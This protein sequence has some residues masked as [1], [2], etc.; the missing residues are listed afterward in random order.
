MSNVTETQLGE[1]MTRFLQRLSQLAEEILPLPVASRLLHLSLL[2]ARVDC[3]VSTQFG[4]AF[5]FTPASV[6]TVHEN[7]RGSRSSTVGACRRSEH[8]RSLELLFGDDPSAPA[9]VS[10]PRGCE[11]Q[12]W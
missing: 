11:Y 7:R 1:Y 12:V 4:V 8:E 3:Y 9:L 10:R 6:T 5:E 2:P